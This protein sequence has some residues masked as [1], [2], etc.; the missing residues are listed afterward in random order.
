M[1]IFRRETYTRERER[2]NKVL[3]VTSVCPTIGG[4]LILYLREESRF[5]FKGDEE[6]ISISFSF[7]ARNIEEP[8]RM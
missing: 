4:C 5:V 6:K 3:Y 1:Q 7:F 8:L 2:E